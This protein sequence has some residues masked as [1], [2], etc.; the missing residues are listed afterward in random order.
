MGTKICGCCFGGVAA[1]EGSR[2]HSSKLHAMRWRRSPGTTHMRLWHCKGLLP[3]LDEDTTGE[4]LAGQHAAEPLWHSRINSWQQ[5]SLVGAIRAAE[6]NPCSWLTP[7]VSKWMFSCRGGGQSKSTNHG[8]LP[9]TGGRFAKPNQHMNEWKQLW[10]GVA[11]IL[12]RVC[13]NL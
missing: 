3:S 13:K 7:T 2:T 6:A 4:H 11:P 12:H 1:M 8:P 10:S 9:C 5:H